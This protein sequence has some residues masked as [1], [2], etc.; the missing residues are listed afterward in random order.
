MIASQENRERKYTTTAW[1]S[2]PRMHSNHRT[3]FAGPGLTARAPNKQLREGGLGYGISLSPRSAG[4]GAKGPG[5]HGSKGSR[6]GTSTSLGFGRA[7][8]GFGR[9][10]A[11]SLQ[12]GFPL[13][14]TWRLASRENWRRSL[15]AVAAAAACQGDEPEK[16]GAELPPVPSKHS[17]DVHRRFL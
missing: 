10:G 2:C 5:W 1:A 15:L 9:A 17:N 12:P 14:L 3:R 13:R 16:A 4:T 7:F 11:V 8:R 6:L